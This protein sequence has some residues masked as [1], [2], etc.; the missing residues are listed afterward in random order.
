MSA[1]K[2]PATK[3]VEGVRWVERSKIRRPALPVQ[4]GGQDL[5]HE[6]L[7][8]LAAPPAAPVHRAESF[9]QHISGP[10]RARLLVHAQISGDAPRIQRRE[11]REREAGQALLQARAR[12]GLGDAQTLSDLGLEQH[13]G[14]NGAPVS[15][16]VVGGGFERV[17]YGMTEVQDLAV[18]ALPL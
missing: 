13:T 11:G 8:D 16:S 2:P 4:R 5:A 3:A 17:P 12:A 7:R 10:A 1:I 18:S 6:G 9:Q 14:G 15:Q